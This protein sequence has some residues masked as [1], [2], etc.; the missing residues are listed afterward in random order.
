MEPSMITVY[1]EEIWLRGEQQVR[2][3]V[4]AVLGGLIGG[5][6]TM[7]V[8]GKPARDMNAQVVAGAMVALRQA[9]LM[10]TTPVVAHLR[11]ALSLLMVG[12]QVPPAPLTAAVLQRWVQVNQFWPNVEREV[13][14]QDE[15]LRGAVETAKAMIEQEAD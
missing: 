9:D 10:A 11:L 2:A 8:Q 1:K 15:A 5:L 3:R 14:R 4:I 6:G 12:N 13:R 7:A